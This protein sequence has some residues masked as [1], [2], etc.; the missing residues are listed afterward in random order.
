M[1]RAL[2]TLLPFLALALAPATGARAGRDVARST[3]RARRSTRGASP[4]AERLAKQ[5]M[6]AGGTQR[7]VALAL[8][9][10]VLAAQGKVDAAIALLDPQKTAQGVG[11]RRVRIEL[12]ELLIRAGRR[13][14]AEPVLH[15]VRERVR[16]RRH[17]VE[18]R[19]GARHGGARDAPA[20]APEGREPGLQGEHAR[21]REPRSRRTS[22]GRRSSRTTSIRATPRRSSNEALKL[23]PEERRRAW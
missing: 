1:K 14:D 8:E 12:G 9:A 17:P 18:R 22:G 3:R 21:R 7:L 10:Q 23:A 15:G 4:D 13:A 2:L 19:R 11:G 6:A 16:Q 5:A 20:A